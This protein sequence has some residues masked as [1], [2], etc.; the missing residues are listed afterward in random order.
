MRWLFSAGYW[1]CSVC[2]PGRFWLG[3]GCD[4]V[5]FLGSSLSPFSRSCAEGQGFMDRATEAEP[6]LLTQD[7]ATLIILADVDAGA[8]FGAVQFLFSAESPHRGMTIPEAFHITIE[9]HAPVGYS[10]QESGG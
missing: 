8:T 4:W 6:Q 9:H 3:T 7:D 5:F 1:G 10:V 2:W